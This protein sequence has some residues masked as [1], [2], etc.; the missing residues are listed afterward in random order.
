MIK[1]VACGRIAKDCKK[2]TWRNSEGRDRIGYSFG[3][4]CERFYGDENPTYIQCTLYRAGDSME[5]WLTTGRQLIVHGNLTRKEQYYNIDVDEFNFGA[6]P[7]N[8]TRNANASG[9]RDGYRYEMDQQYRGDYS[10]DGEG[11]RSHGRPQGQ[12]AQGNHDGE[13]PVG[14]YSGYY[15]EN[16]T[17][18]DPSEV[19]F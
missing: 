3:L 9:Q 16:G 13:Q 5:R 14:Q 18:M 7:A 10:R 2:F 6:E 4:I 8:S 1:V 15:D 19:P 17:P 11:G 12:Q